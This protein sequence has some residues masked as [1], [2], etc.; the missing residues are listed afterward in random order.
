MFTSI[1][2]NS[3]SYITFEQIALCFFGALLCG[4]VIALAYHMLADMSRSFALTLTLLP[5]IVMM[6]IMMVNGNLG[7]GVAVAGSFSLVRFRSQP[8][9]ASDI[10][11]IFLAMGAGLAC[12]MGY[13]TFALAMVILCIAAAVLFSK[14]PLFSTPSGQRYLMIQVPEDLNDA[15]AFDD[16]FEKYTSSAQLMEVRTTHMGM[17]NELQY[18][19][20]LKQSSQEQALINELR[21]CNGNLTIRSTIQAPVTI[22]L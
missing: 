22:Q 20:D 16:L 8:G 14:L 4:F 19:I 2:S 3:A 10:G 9:K 13:I 17:L 7:V 6:V 18:R 11:V 1:L 12:G 21:M 15:N 5:A